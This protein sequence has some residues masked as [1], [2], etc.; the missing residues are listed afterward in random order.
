MGDTG[1]LV[2]TL[3]LDAHQI[4]LY[5]PSTHKCCPADCVCVYVEKEREITFKR[6]SQT[7]LVSLHHTVSTL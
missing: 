3:E 7:F 1:G 5:T 2:C 4:L 6:L